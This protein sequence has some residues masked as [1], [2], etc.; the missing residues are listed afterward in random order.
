MW[1]NCPVHGPWM[2]QEHSDAQE[3]V[4]TV[5]S[6]PRAARPADNYGPWVSPGLDAT[7]EE[8]QRGTNNPN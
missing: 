3:Q 7:Q 2:Q 1:T 5:T 4:A 6:Q 8:S